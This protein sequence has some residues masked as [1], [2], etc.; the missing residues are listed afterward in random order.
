MLISMGTIRYFF[1]NLR[2]I[3]FKFHKNI[4]HFKSENEARC[5]YKTMKSPDDIYEN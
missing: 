2:K 4:F 1:L 3:Q 5:I